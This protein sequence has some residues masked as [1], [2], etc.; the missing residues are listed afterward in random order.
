MVPRRAEIWAIVRNGTLKREPKDDFDNRKRFNV[1]RS[2]KSMIYGPG[3]FGM[4]CCLINRRFQLL[5]F[6]SV[7]QLEAGKRCFRLTT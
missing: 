2:E 4:G 3:F 5:Y 1:I 6:L 7:V